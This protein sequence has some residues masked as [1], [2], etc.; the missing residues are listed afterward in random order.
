HAR[1]LA[2]GVRTRPWTRRVRRARG[3]ASIADRNHPRPHGP[4]EAGGVPDT[5]IDK[6]E[7]W[8]LPAMVGAV[9]AIVVLPFMFLSSVLQA[10]AAAARE[11]EQTGRVE[12]TL[13]ALAYDIRDN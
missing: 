10:G 11:V 2:R 8:Q 4:G 7:R 6:R 5:H 3:R 1:I 13:H 12:A 9:I